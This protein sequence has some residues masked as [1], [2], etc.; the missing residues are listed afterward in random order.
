[1]G[2][3]AWV[4]EHAFNL[5]EAAGIIGSLVFTSVSLRA[6]T[7]TRKVSNLLTL[8]AN[9]REI[10][11]EFFDRP[12]LARVLDASLDAKRITIT[13]EELEFVNLVI[14]HTST[15]YEALKGKLVVKQEGL[16]RDVGVFLSLP[17]PNAVWNKMK[18]FHNADFVRFVEKVIGSMR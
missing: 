16:P 14:I 1:M 4:T 2:Y 9:H 8:T 11:R 6:E 17:I 18:Q 3:W 7:K 10:W 5:L 15:M 13:P 12:E